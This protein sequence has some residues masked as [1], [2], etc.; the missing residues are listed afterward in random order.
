MS[1]KIHTCCGCSC[2]VCAD[3]HCDTGQHED[4]CFER[5]VS[6]TV[7]AEMT[8]GEMSEENKFGARLRSVISGLDLQMFEDP[9][10]LLLCISREIDQDAKELEERVRKDELA[11]VAETRRERA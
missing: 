2:R 8:E 5:L 6:G 9:G 1:H 7:V 11:R 3:G 4:G 10:D